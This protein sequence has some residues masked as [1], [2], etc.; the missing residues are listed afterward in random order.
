MII[1]PDFIWLHFPKCAGTSVEMA[2]RAIY[3][4]QRG[5]YF[6]PIG[7]QHPVIWHDTIWLRRQRDPNFSPDG[8]RILCCFRRLPSWIL[9]RVHFI[10]TRD[11]RLTSTREML[12][13]G[14]FRENNGN[15]NNPDNYLRGFVASKPTTWLRTE[16]ILAD[17]SA[18]LGL[19]ES[20][21][22]EHLPHEKHG[23]SYIRNVDFWF[24]TEE[25]DRLYAACP[26]WA[27]WELKV[28]GNLLSQIPRGSDV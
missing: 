19:P 23:L 15:I 18:A 26:L 10:A 13:A 16:N 11:E 20:K 25:L 12:R 1:G 4:R 17:L 21:V 9:S 6:D 14:R 28:Y 8:R 24:T 7:A 3:K 27:E 22:R 5:Y 2:L